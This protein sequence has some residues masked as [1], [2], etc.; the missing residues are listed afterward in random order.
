MKAS[1]L[2][3]IFAVAGLLAILL[4]LL[5]FGLRSSGYT[6]KNGDKKAT[7]RV[8]PNNLFAYDSVFGCKMNP[9]HY[10]IYQPKTQYDVTVDAYGHRITS[11]TDSATDSLRPEII[12][13]GGPSIFGHG[14]NDDETCPFFLQSL[15]P[16]YKVI[17]LALPNSG[18][19]DN[20]LQL[21]H[22]QQIRDSDLVVYVYHS[23]H[24]NRG[25][26]SNLKQ[27]KLDGSDIEYQFPTLDSNLVPHLNKYHHT[28]FPFS[29]HCAIT[30]YLEINYNRWINQDKDSHTIAEKAILAMNTWC[31]T[32][33][34]RFVLV[35][36][37]P[38]KYRD[39]TIEYCN[40]HDIKT[41]RFKAD[42]SFK[43]LVGHQPLSMANKAFADSLVSHFTA[44]GLLNAPTALATPK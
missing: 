40:A 14:I 33:K 38:D 21:T 43:D 6:P 37:Q 26:M 22:F 29:S 32:H 39:E 35:Y 24:D 2:R 7:M 30:N 10:H 15:L 36:W 17:N 27:L 12:F 44:V 16:Q 1:A 23:L 5:E 20:Y 8:Q 19:A 25:K 34:C 41:V 28:K 42:I 4:I 9:G 13:L 18:L 31:A 11:F 3:K